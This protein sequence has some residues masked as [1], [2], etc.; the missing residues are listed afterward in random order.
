[1]LK[2]SI[3]HFDGKIVEMKEFL[4]TDLDLFFD[5]IT[6]KEVY[7]NRLTGRGIWVN[8][9]TVRHVLVEKMFLPKNDTSK[10]KDNLEK[11]KKIVES[12]DTD[13]SLEQ[14]SKENSEAT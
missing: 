12:K 9:A 10:A 1:M 2:L 3:L 6:R 14:N 13:Q 11:K 7:W 4:D 8:V 5:C